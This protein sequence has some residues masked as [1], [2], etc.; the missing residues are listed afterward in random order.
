MRLCEQANHFTQG[1][2]NLV[3]SLPQFGGSEVSGGNLIFRGTG[4]TSN[5]TY[6]VLT[7]TNLTQPLTNRTRPL[8]NQF[9][10]NGNFN[11]TNLMAPSAPQSFYQLQIP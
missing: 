7:S 4:G 8:T 3:V 5:G 9:D 2:V 11:F 1:L 6:Y 10:G